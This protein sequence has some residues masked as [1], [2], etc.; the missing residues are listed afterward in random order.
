MASA[1]AC[2]RRNGL[3]VGMTARMQRQ[4]VRQQIGIEF[5]GVSS[6]GHRRKG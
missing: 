1:G 6:M 2:V 4:T 3:D 5:A